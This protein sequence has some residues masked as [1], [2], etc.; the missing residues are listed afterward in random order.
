METYERLKHLRKDTLKMSQAAFGAKLG[1]NRDVINNI[2]G[3]RLAKPEQKLSLFKLICSEFHVNED[4]LLNG[5]GEMFVSNE[6]E[7]STL[8]DRALS[9]EN[10]FVKNVFKTFALFDAKDWDALQHMVEKY[11]SVADSDSEADINKLYSELPS[12]KDIE[13]EYSPVDTKK[14]DVG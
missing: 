14:K 1:V 13:K 9:G 11:N 7:Y 8:I 12:G 5:N 2:E 10:E 3:N 4:W 6:A